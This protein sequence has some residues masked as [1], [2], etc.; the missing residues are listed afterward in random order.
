MEASIL[1]GFISSV[2]SVR[3]LLD[4]ANVHSFAAQS[5]GVSPEAELTLIRTQTY[6][7]VRSMV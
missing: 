4:L 7:G 5:T 1:A 2:G 6:S 3:R